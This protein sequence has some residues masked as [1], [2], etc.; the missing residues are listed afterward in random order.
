M[1]I[2]LVLLAEQ[3]FP[4][5]QT[6]MKPYAHPVLEGSPMHYFNYRISSAKC[7]V[8]N[9]FG[10][11]KARFRILHMPECYIDSVKRII[12]SCC[13]LHNICEQL[14]DC[15]DV[16][17]VDAATKVDRRLRQPVCTTIPVEPLVWL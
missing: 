8:D 10:R 4:L 7:V 12:S 13:V 3:S 11:L 2:G 14:N 6:I 15:C 16:L 1:E 9:V 5:Q 17:W